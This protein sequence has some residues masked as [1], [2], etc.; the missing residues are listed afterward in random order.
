VAGVAHAGGGMMVTNKSP[1]VE[2]SLAV[3]DGQ[4]FAG[5]IT[6]VGADFVACDAAGRLIGK[7]R[8]LRAASRA[9][10]PPAA[11]LGL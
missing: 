1:K 6:E 2:H 3:Y 5:S 7:F 10:I 9:I 11:E 8:T 4:F